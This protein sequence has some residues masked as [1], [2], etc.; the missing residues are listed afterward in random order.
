MQTLSTLLRH[1]ITYLVGLLVAGLTVYLT[2][3]GEAAA[4]VAAAHALIEPL[5]VL[6]GLA[7]VVLSR[8]ALPVVAKVF[9][10]GAGEKSGG[11]SGGILPSAFGWIG[12][13]IGTAVA[14]LGALP[15]CS[16][17]PDGIPVGIT[18]TLGK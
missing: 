5:V 10:A 4:A 9:R 14:S 3:P 18:L 6:A 15:S 8:L 11:G 1:G 17:Y 13:A 16:A 12:L 2:S 7:A